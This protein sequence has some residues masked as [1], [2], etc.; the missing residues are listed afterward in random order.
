MCL[1]PELSIFL[2]LRNA[3]ERELLEQGICPAEKVVV[4]DT[5]DGKHVVVVDVEVAM[6]RESDIL[7]EVTELG[8][9]GAGRK[10][11]MPTGV[12]ALSTSVFSEIGPGYNLY[13]A[14]ESPQKSYGTESKCW[15]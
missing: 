1:V 13:S 12:F 6:F 11:G 2:L 7:P 8:H 9:V 5:W 4:K 10:R 14:Q 3:T 15:Y